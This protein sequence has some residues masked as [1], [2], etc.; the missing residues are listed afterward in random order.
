MNVK[1]QDDEGDADVRV[2][3]LERYNLDDLEGECSKC[4][5][6]IFYRP[7]PPYLVTFLCMECARPLFEQE[8][9]HEFRVS[10]KT[11]E[12]IRRLL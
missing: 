7:E 9:S 6:P 8:Q 5:K 1:I 11:A 4:K 2:A 12:M 10:T 3:T